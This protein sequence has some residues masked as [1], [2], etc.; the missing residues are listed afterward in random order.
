MC[1]PERASVQEPPLSLLQRSVLSGKNQGQAFH[2]ACPTAERVF[3][4][5]CHD[6]S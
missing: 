1:V 2:Q 5:L 3:F 4:V 6:A